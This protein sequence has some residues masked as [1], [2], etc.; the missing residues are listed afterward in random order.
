MSLRLMSRSVL[1]FVLAVLAASLLGSVIQSQF[2]LAQIAAL[3][4][5]VPPALWWSTTLEDMVGFGPLYAAMM[6]V[7][8]LPALLVAALVCRWLPPGEALRL[9]VFAAAGAVGIFAA[10]QLANMAAPM[11]T[12]IA[13]TRG[14]GG[15]LAMMLSGA[16]GGWVF[17]RLHSLDQRLPQHTPA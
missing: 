5:E 10:F 16:L 12:L 13:A 6:A 14:L 7:A 17:A 11:P 1:Y 2:N 8:L 4:A 3:G 15:T 9:T